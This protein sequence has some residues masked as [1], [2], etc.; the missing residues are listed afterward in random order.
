MMKI[1]TIYLKR[2]LLYGGCLL[3]PVFVMAQELGQSLGSLD[4]RPSLVNP[5]L[6][7]PTQ[8]T[9]VHVVSPGEYF[10]PPLV[11]DIPDDKYGDMV[12][13]GR[14]IFVNSAKYAKRYAGNGLN[15]SSCHLQEGRKPHSGPLWAA[16][17]MYP[18]YRHKTRTVVTFE[19]R[20]QDCFLYSMDGIAPTLDSPEMKALVTYAQWLSK[21]APVGIKLPGRG[22]PIVNRSQDLDSKRGK[23]VYETRCEIC[24]GEDGKGKKH[25]QGDGYMFPPLWGRN[26]YNK[27]AGMQRIKTLAQFIK[28][29]MPLGASFSL[30]DQESLDVAMYIWLQDRPK[31]PKM[32]WVMDFFLPNMAH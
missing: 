4:V 28:G 9:Q 16:F 19:E 11:A 6:S 14:N 18:M 10:S 7:L 31:N 24:H 12:R 22:F 3:F 32:S 30:S 23:I 20:I 17:G 29:N 8:L 13:M 2:V 21:G 5:R 25:L 1:N 26:S 27:G 15:C